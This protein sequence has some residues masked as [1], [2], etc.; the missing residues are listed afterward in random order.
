[1]ATAQ[2]HPPKDRRPSRCRQVPARALEATR[3]RPDIDR[4]KTSY[5]T[6]IQVRQIDRVL[7][8]SEP[9]LLFLPL[10]VALNWALPR[11]LRPGFLVAASYYFYASWNPP[12]L[13]LIF[14]LTIANYFLGL[15]Q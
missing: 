14:V 4:H 11:P 9:Y 10:V 5:R 3:H 13:L 7:F 6:E 1:M 12:Y 8:N 15:A 2:G